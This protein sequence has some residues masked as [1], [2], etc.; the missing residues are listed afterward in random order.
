[1]R[2]AADP[3]YPPMAART[4]SFHVRCLVEYL[5]ALLD[6]RLEAGDRALVLLLAG[7]RVATRALQVELGRLQVSRGGTEL[8]GQRALLLLEQRQRLLLFVLGKQ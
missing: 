5:A 4:A 8:L 6:F 7:G 1:M 3:L 2:P